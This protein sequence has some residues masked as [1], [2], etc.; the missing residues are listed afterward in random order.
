M[1]ADGLARKA[2]KRW[3]QVSRLKGPMV[4]RAGP[5]RSSERGSGGVPRP[6][7]GARAPAPT[8]KGHC[9]PRAPRRSQ[10]PSVTRRRQQ[11]PRARVP[12]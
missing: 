3:A 2:P 12:R 6:P 5:C 9:C 11:G 1:K 10:P 7:E 4:R 8:R